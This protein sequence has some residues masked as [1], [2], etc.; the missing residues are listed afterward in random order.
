MERRAWD[1][2][3]TRY[4]LRIDEKGRNE[5]EGWSHTSVFLYIARDILSAMD[6][7]SYET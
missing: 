6:Y 5:R 3:E 7:Q 1:V 4:G 2:E